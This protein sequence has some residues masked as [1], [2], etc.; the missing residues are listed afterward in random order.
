MVRFKVITSASPHEQVDTIVTV[1]GFAST[2]SLSSA[3]ACRFGMRADVKCFSLSG[4][5]CAGGMVAIEL[6]SEL[7]Q[8]LHSPSLRYCLWH[9]RWPLSLQ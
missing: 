1:S 5:G 8:V 6:A 3:V 9:G 4:H 7:L 2:P